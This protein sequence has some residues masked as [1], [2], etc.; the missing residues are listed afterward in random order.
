MTMKRTIFDKVRFNNGYE[1][2]Q[3]SIGPDVDD[4]SQDAALVT[5]EID[6]YVAPTYKQFL[7]LMD[8]SI[9]CGYRSFDSGA[10]YGTE[11]PLGDYF[12]SCGLARDE[13]FITT[14]VNN[15]MHGYDN[16]MRDFENSYK[17]IGLD[18]VDLYLIH[19][20]VPMFGLYEDT[21]KAFEEIYKSGLV[22]AIGVSNF[23]VQQLYDLSDISD[24]VPVVN[25]REQTPF[26]VQAN[27][28]AYEKRHGILQQSYSPLG[29]GKFAKD[30]RLQW[31]ADKYEKT[32]AQV[33]LR[34]HLQKGFMCVTSSTKTSRIRQNTDIFD[35]ELTQEDMAYISTLN[36]GERVWHDPSRFQGTVAHMT[37]EKELRR[38]IQKE[39]DLLS[40]QDEEKEQILSDINICLQQKDVDDTLDY[41]MYCFYRAEAKG[42]RGADITDRAVTEAAAVAKELVKKQRR[43][44]DR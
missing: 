14:K 31:I 3:Y 4:S 43:D 13:L 28:I 1:M 17:S 9:E 25:Q 7:E 18:Y 39:I 24:I 16:T 23:T 20:P 34:W 40:V 2:P 32:V 36:H 30:P 15:K 6:G 26:Y 41:V 44:N 12:K 29:Q 19:C 37:V 22:K 42:G 35:F 33:I 27:L 10:R 21:W 11:K 5:G 38:Y 8:T